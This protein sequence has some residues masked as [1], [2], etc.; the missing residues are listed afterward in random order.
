MKTNPSALP[1]LITARSQSKASVYGPALDGGTGLTD[2]ATFQL[3]PGMRII[4]DETLLL[5][6]AEARREGYD[7]AVAGL[8]A[9]AGALS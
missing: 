2:Y 9:L 7:E 4:S 3:S 1:A 8:A 5:A 6:L